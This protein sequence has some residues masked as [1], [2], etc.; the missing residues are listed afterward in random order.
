M[1]AASVRVARFVWR[2]YPI[3][4]LLLAW[5]TV[6]WFRLVSPRLMPGLEEIFAALIRFAQRGDLAFHAAITLERAAY[7]FGGAIVAGIALGTL[8][9]RSRWAEALIEPIFSFGYPMPKFALY[10]VFIFIFGFGDASKIALVFLECMYPMTVQT[11]HGMR[12]AERVLVWAARN[13][14]ASRRDLFFRVLAPSAAPSIF[15]GIRI[16]LPIA[17]I[18][19]IVTEIIGESRGLGYLINFNAI[20]FE[21]GRALAALFV[22]AVIGFIF[23]RTVV[24]LQRKIIFWQ[25][26][27]R[28]L[29]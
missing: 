29:T 5:E 23:D 17:F 1:T 19:T 8:M 13:M 4:V 6:T 7:G 28:L 18:L 10:P 15:A 16:A 20:S 25:Q 27:A 3:I 22:V 9:A 12:S 2:F 24:Y 21:T 14:G 11:F 26:G